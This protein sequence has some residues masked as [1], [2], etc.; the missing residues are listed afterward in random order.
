[1]EGDGGVI[2]IAMVITALGA[3]IGAGWYLLHPASDQQQQIMPLLGK[4][5]GQLEPMSQLARQQEQAQSKRQADIDA[6][7]K[8]AP[9]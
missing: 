2:R 6:V 8:A 9:K 7:L 4:I 5:S 1:M 3:T